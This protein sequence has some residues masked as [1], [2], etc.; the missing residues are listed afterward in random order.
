MADQETAVRQTFADNLRDAFL[1]LLRR[2]GR[3]RMSREEL[4]ERVAKALGRR[5]PLDQSTV[6]GW[7]QGSIPPAHTGMALAR[8]LGTT[9]GALLGESADAP[10]SREDAPGRPVNRVERGRE[11]LR[12][13]AVDKAA[14]KKRRT[15]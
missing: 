6:R 7:F 4:G 5:A 2:E 14:R 9:F 1:D 3:E 11:V 15:S 8:V 13:T 10:Q 12:E